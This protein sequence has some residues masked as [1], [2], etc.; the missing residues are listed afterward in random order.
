MASAGTKLIVVAIL[1]VTA[2]LRPTWLTLLT[3]GGIVVAGSAIFILE[4]T[5]M[6]FMHSSSFYRAVATAFPVALI[7]ITVVSKKRWPAPMISFCE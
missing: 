5:P 1:S 6:E 7:A 4:S 3:I 2:S